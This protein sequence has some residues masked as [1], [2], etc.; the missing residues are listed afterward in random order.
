MVQVEAALFARELSTWANVSCTGYSSAGL[1][2]SRARLRFA[3]AF[4]SRSA[5]ETWW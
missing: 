4:L 1:L 3:L 2:P 5:P